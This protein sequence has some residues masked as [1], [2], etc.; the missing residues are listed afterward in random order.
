MTEG[1]DPGVYN[2]DFWLWRPVLR[3][4]ATLEEIET[5]WSLTDMLDAHEAL[6]IMDEM[7]TYANKQASKGR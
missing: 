6:D 2:V 3:K 4:I 7:E 5:H 1:F